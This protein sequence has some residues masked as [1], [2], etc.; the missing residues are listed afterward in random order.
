MRPRRR[1][2]RR[3][4]LLL[5]SADDH[6]QLAESTVAVVVTPSRSL[7]PATRAMNARNLAELAGRQQALG[8]NL[9]AQE[10]SHSHHFSRRCKRNTEGVRRSD[11]ACSS[12]CCDD[13][14]SRMEAGIATAQQKRYDQWERNAAARHRLMPRVACRALY[15]R[16][17]AS[18]LQ[19]TPRRR[20]GPPSALRSSLL[21]PSNVR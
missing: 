9:R 21:L 6:A 8:V 4:A 10:Q 1:R 7:A 19:L 17:P 20:T 2:R 16:S 12:G 3:T 11:S 5:L 14:R 15:T 13:L 18:S